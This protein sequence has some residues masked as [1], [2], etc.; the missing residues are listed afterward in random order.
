[1]RQC[2][3]TSLALKAVNYSRYIANVWLTLEKP[4]LC[5]ACLRK[6]GYYREKGAV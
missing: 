3:L 6:R 5:L 2:H 4:A 1:M